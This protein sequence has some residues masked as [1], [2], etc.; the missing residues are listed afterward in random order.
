VTSTMPSEGKTLTSINLAVAHAQTGKRTLL[1]DTDMRKPRLNKLFPGR[2][3]RGLSNLLAAAPGSLMPSELIVPTRVD[4]LFFLPTGPIPPNPVEMLDSN[5]FNQLV[6]ELQS[7]YDLLIFDSPPALN[8]VDSLVI[9]KRVDGM[10]LVVRSFVTNKFAAKQVARQ[11]G[12]SK[13][14]LLGV[15]LNNVDMPSG[16]DYYSSYYYSRYGSYYAE[17]SASGS[18]GRPSWWAPLAGRLGGG[19]KRRS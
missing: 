14:K 16:T 15:V 12:L 4:N 1:V 6:A 10:V 13:V 9:G 19:R 11:V 3:S 17:E 5:R 18:A 2:D 8:L 7:Q